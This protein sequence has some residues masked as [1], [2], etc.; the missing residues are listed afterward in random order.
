MTSRKALEQLALEF[1]A[2]PRV[3]APRVVTYPDLVALS[4]AHAA[5]NI[6]KVF[7]HWGNV[8]FRTNGG[9]CRE[10]VGHL[11][12]DKPN[13][14]CGFWVLQLNPKYDGN[15]PY[16]GSNTR[17]LGGALSLGPDAMIAYQRCETD[18][19]TVYGEAD[20]QTWREYIAVH[21][22][23][24]DYRHLLNREWS[25]VAKLLPRTAE[26]QGVAES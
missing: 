12:H 23:P 9:L 6:P 24:D 4:S 16:R 18:E 14:Y 10:A 7:Q 21:K 20:L 3:E 13:C 5:A 15:K 25:E 22:G 26:P 2:P 19:W 17:F 8:R 11:N 1:P